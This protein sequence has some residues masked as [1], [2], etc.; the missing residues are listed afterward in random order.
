MMINSKMCASQTQP[1]RTGKINIGDTERAISIM[2]GG[3]ILLKGVAKLP[4]VTLAAVVA[5]GAL[6]YRGLTGHC[7][8]YEALGV[9]SACN[10]ENRPDNERAGPLPVFTDGALA[11]TD[12]S[13][14]I[15]R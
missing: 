14:P 13:P 9:S 8:A 5:G 6:V 4:F 1:V 3:L 7:Q 10:L 2:A 15:S 12:G 11:S